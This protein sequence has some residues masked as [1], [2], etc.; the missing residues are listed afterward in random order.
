[1][2]RKL[3]ILLTL[4]GSTTIAS[5]QETWT[6]RRM[7]DHA[8][9]QNISVKQADV[10]ARIQALVLQQAK[11][12]QLP[13][14]SFGTGLGMQFG[15]SI[16]PT[17]NQFTTTQLLFNNLSVNGG[18][19]LYNAGQIKN[20][21]AY[22]AL[23]V[24]ASLADKAKAAN[25]IA[26]SVCNFYLQALAAREQVKISAVQIGQTKAQLD[27]T[28]KR[29]E[30]GNLPEL[31]VAELEA[32][33]AN[34]S[35]N[36]ITSEVNF[37]QAVLS[38]KALLNLN[39]AEP[40]AIDTP[41][42]N[43]IPLQGLLDLQPDYVYN[44]ARN[45]QPQQLGDSLRIAAAKQNIKIVRAGFYPTVSF[46]YNLTSAF[47]NTL[48]TIDPSSFAI[49]GAAPTGSFVTVGGTN[50]A[51]LE[52]T[53]AFKTMQ[54]NFGQWWDGYGRQVDQNFRQSVAFQVN[55]PIFN[56]ANNTRISYNRAKLDVQNQ[57]LVQQGNLQKLQ[58]DIYTAYTAAEAAMRRFY[59]GQKSVESAQKA[60]EFALKRYDAGLLP[61]IDL[62]TNQNNLLRAKLQQLN[63]QYDYIFRMKLLEFY[64]GQGLQL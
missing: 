21:I 22:S 36:Y 4:A 27:I 12:N 25:D 8:M 59:A 39:M 46:G 54:R 58:Q 24:Q 2:L 62:I 28:R 33:L 9:Q 60:Y 1:M 64:K 56:N 17:T 31:N 30:A 37:Q 51:V 5:A 55:V 13:S 38:L 35:S 61:T 49:T 50:Y 15:R 43:N 34:D 42:V 45:N 23:L 41:S 3:I 20:N 29:V 18:I 16:D 48:K 47:A 53:V 11:Y 52:P 40:F 44:L 7:V 19:Q 57:Q 32:Q 63:N 14:A 26:L 6:L 10:Q